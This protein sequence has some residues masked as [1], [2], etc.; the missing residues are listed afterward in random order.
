VTASAT[1]D[2]FRAA[3][4]VRR[5][6]HGGAFWQHRATGAG[7]RDSLK[8]L[9]PGARV[10]TFPGAGHAISA[11]RRDEWAAEIAAFLAQVSDTVVK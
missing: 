3:A 9:Y 11:E 6:Q 7:A 10:R 2:A 4:P 8:S 5:L 1:L